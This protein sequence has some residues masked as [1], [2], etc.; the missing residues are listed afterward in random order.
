MYKL[1]KT[2]LPVVI[3][4]CCVKRIVISTFGCY[5]NKAMLNIEHD[6][7]LEKLPDAQKIIPNKSTDVCIGS[8]LR[9]IVHFPKIPLEALQYPWLA[10]AR[11]ILKETFKKSDFL[12]LQLEAITTIMEGKDCLIIKSTGG[13]KSLCYQLPALLKNGYCIVIS[14]LLSL[15]NDQI[16]K[17]NDLGIPSI[18]LNSLLPRDEYKNVLDDLENQIMNYKIIYITPEQYAYGRRLKKLIKMNSKDG[19]LSFIAIDEIHCLKDWGETYRGTYKALRNLRN[20]VKCPVV[21]LTATANNEHIEYFKKNLIF[22][23]PVVLKSTVIRNNLFY[24]RIWKEKDSSLQVYEIIKS[25]FFNQT[26][27]VYCLSIKESEKLGEYLRVNGISATFYHG[28]LDRDKR[29]QILQ[30]WLD[31]KIKV[32]VSTSAFGMGVD[33][34]NVRF[35]IHHAMP[36]R[37]VDFVQETGR[38]GR[39]GLP[40]TCL[41]LF[42][43]YDATRRIKLNINKPDILE[44]IH[45]MVKLLNSN[46]CKRRAIATSFD[47]TFDEEEC[48]KECE[49]CNCSIDDIH[50]GSK[51]L[52]NKILDDSKEIL[53]N[54]NENITQKKLTKA[55]WKMRRH[56]TKDEIDMFLTSLIMEKKLTFKVNKNAESRQAY[57]SIPR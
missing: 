18:A 36:S 37:I 53:K 46:N 5:H 45:Q 27:I 33:K 43:I 17:L 25:R 23:K 8:N 26:G 21:G 29:N 14:P 50:G 51:K 55:L 3:K 19:M 39:D 6:E 7:S 44:D 1:S 52:L 34:G 40:S 48:R 30:D 38:A 22:K 28:K 2:L 31:E 15:M 49:S 57:I 9:S 12:P 13:G 56:W 42:N 11:R 35:V 20:R 54:P 47:E 41:T 24:Q 4:S 10:D 16:I 32:I